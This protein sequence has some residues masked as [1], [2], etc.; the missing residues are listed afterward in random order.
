[1][2]SLRTVL[3]VSLAAAGQAAAAPPASARSVA[4]ALPFPEPQTVDEFMKGLE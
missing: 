1:M 2:T 4:P 3:V